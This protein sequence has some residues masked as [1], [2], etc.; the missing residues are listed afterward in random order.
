MDGDVWARNVQLQRRTFGRAREPLAVR[1]LLRPLTRAAIP[2]A[3]WTLCLVAAVAAV[4]ADREAR[5]ARRSID[6][7]RSELARANKRSKLHLAVLDRRIKAVS[8]PLHAALVWPV[9]GAVT[10]PFGDRGYEFHPGVDIDAPAG[11]PVRPAA[12]GLVVAAGEESGYG[13]RVVIDH[14][15]GLQT[16]YAHLE[17]V[18][19]STGEAVTSA[20]T[21][22]AVG[23]TG[24]CDGT[25]L[26]F[27]VRLDGRKS[28]P[29]LWLP[30]QSRAVAALT[31]GG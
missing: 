20:S 23:C 27:E 16:V 10:S 2:L 11:A 3:L 25:H 6:G 17:R 8:H 18:T 28:D 13:N 1:R 22:G 12:A 15:R 4:R 21:I 7:V 30:Q 31:W 14:G 5:E 24:M 29:S 9:N 26:H 19:V